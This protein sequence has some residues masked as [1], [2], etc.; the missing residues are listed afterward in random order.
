MK[1]TRRNFIKTVAVGIVGNGIL[2]GLPIE[3]FAN[4]GDY[5]DGIEI[6]KGFKVF[7][8]ETQ[9]SMEALAETLLPGAKEIGIKGMFMN[10]VATNPGPAGF[11]DA[12][13]WNLD[14]ISKTQFKKAFYKLTSKEEKKA[15]IDHVSVR[16]RSF[17]LGFRKTITELYYTHPAVWKKLSYTGPPQPKGFM[18][19]YLP[20]KGAS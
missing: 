12:G 16:N 3:L 13:F 15:V 6:Q 11:F 1:P 20:P 10:Y 19:Y 5:E 2:S 18:D 8:S 4:T 14:T 17:F 7:N 9:K